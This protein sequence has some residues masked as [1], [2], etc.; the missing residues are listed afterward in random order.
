MKVTVTGIEVVQSIQDK[1]NNVP[2]FESRAT[3]VRVYTS[4]SDITKKT[5]IMG[6]LEVEQ[7]ATP[8]FAL[9]SLSFVSIS[10]SGS[11]SL[12]TQREELSGSLN[13]RIERNAGE[14]I[15]KRGSVC[16]RLSRVWDITDP[17]T[18]LEINTADGSHC[19]RLP[20]EKPTTLRVHVVGMSTSEGPPL[21][22]DDPGFKRIHDEIL[23]L[24]PVSKL[25]FTND[26]IAAPPEVDGTFEW[27]VGKQRNV[28]WERKHNIICAQLMAQ[29]VCDIESEEGPKK[30]L[31]KTI[32]CGMVAH[33]GSLQDAAVSNVATVARPSIVSAGPAGRGAE[34]FAVHEIGHV[35]T[36]L[37]PG[38]PPEIQCRTDPN[39]PVSYRGRISDKT[40]NHMGW[41]AGRKESTGKLLPYKDTRDF[42]GYVMSSGISVHNY[43]IA[44][45]G[46]SEI[47]AFQPEI[48]E[49]G[50]IAVIGVFDKHSG[51][52]SGE[53][54]HL[55]RSSYRIPRAEKS[56]PDVQIRVNFHNRDS[57]LHEIDSKFEK[58]AL[59]WRSGPFQLSVP[60]ADDIAS[61]EL[62]IHGQTKHTKSVDFVRDGRVGV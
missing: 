40:D 16:F 38:F 24:L 10:D 47:E 56:D 14:N 26:V 48:C 17:G 58:G 22:L 43:K 29:R 62:L 20:V 44:A 2:L 37:H 60:D 31:P 57:E 61:F 8:S 19:R 39:F 51:T 55:Y 27:T 23:D 9:K 36:C 34:I 4:V 15:L 30:E 59:H 32:Y 21:E 52:V 18:S 3:L 54:R 50:C 5:T 33:D 45:R 49:G 46:L 25:E 7:S 42:M 11:P 35:L 12:D 53:I 41:R 6:E 1:Q 28:D 13:F